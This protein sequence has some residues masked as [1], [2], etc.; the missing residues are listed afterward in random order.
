MFAARA[1]TEEQSGVVEREPSKLWTCPSML[2]DGMRKAEEPVAKNVDGAG[3]VLVE[4]PTSMVTAPGGL[5]EGP[6]IS[7]R[8]ILR[9]PCVIARDVSM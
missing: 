4:L 3:L 9:V 1:E 2:V 7:A 8:S 6:T 5:I